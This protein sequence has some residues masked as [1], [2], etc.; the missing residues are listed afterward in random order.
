MQTA[1][2]SKLVGKTCLFTRNL[3]LQQFKLNI[4]VYINKLLD[5]CILSIITFFQLWMLPSQINQTKR[6]KE[7][8]IW[9]YDAA[10]KP[11]FR[12]CFYHRVFTF[13]TT[14]ISYIKVLRYLWVVALQTLCMFP[15]N[16]H[17]HWIAGRAN[18]PCKYLIF[19]FVQFW[20]WFFRFFLY[21]ISIS[22][23]FLK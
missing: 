1:P 23:S 21:V 19:I 20:A 12:F 2:R 8:L 17:L 10:L 3:L 11:Y 18:I 14:Y 22:S 5:F 15:K 6:N 16:H 9:Y 13:T 7:F 4:F